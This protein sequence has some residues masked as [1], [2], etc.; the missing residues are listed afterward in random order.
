MKPFHL[1]LGLLVL[2]VSDPG[3]SQAESTVHETVRR[4]EDEWAE[5]FYRLPPNQHAEKFKGLLARVHSVSER[6][7]K[8]ADPLV[9]EA[10]VLCTYAAADIGLSSLSKVGKARELLIKAIDIDPRAMEGSAYVTLGNLYYRLPGWPIS[11]GDDD[12]A[13][14]YL[15]AALKLYPNALDSNYFYGDFLLQQGEHEK[16]LG[17]LEK[18]EKAPIRPYMVLSDTKLKEEVRQALTAAREKRNDHG[19]FFSSFLQPFFGDDGGKP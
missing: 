12:S 4:L 7:P 16:A 3:K 6:Y 11:F 14:Q 5:I 18:A 13:R 9:L 1:V 8:E 19:D 15:E 10:I 2:L 17:Y